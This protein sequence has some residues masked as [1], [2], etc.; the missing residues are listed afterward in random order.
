MTLILRGEN[1]FGL[2]DCER[3]PGDTIWTL[4]DAGKM[5]EDDTYIVGYLGIFA[6]DFWPDDLPA[7]SVVEQKYF[8]RCPDCTAAGGADAWREVSGPY[9]IEFELK[10]GSI[11]DPAEIKVRC[12]AY[13][14]TKIHWYVGIVV[15]EN[16]VMTP[17]TITANGTDTSQGSVHI[18]PSYRNVVWSIS[19][20]ALG[21]TINAAG[22]VT[23]G[24]DDGTITVNADGED[25]YS[26]V[27][28]AE[29]S[30]LTLTEP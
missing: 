1:D 26:G 30:D 3:D 2:A 4:D 28:S 23:A 19:G 24:L 6:G 9:D 10:K 7:H 13:G 12:M 29:T 27:F 17:D 25:A 14:E 21:C 15:L 20:A 22:K 8:W 5:T 16:L 18:I 11:I